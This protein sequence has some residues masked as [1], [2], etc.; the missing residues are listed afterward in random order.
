VLLHPEQISAKFDSWVLALIAAIS[1]AAAT[2][3][4]NVVANFVSAAFDI[5]NVFP[6]T[7][8]FKRGGYIAAGIAL[9][10]YPFAPWEGNAAHFVN[11]IGATMGPLLGIILVDFYLIAK[12]KVNV[13]ALYQE[14][15]EYR[16]QGGWNVN[17]LIATGIGSIFS[18]LLPNFTS[19]LPPWWNT[20][21]WFFGVAIGGATYWM[22][23]LLRPRAAGVLATGG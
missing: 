19:L 9:V 8:S 5:S 4:I 6:R 10:L 13:E 18:T 14:H 1:F 17:A 22:L 2:L 11:A 3:G 21:G 23:A 20:Y 12:G 7:I 15:G 16:Y